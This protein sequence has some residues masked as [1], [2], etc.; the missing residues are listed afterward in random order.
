MRPSALTLAP[1]VSEEELKALKESI[2]SVPLR[3]KH[4][5]IGTAAGGTL[6]ELMTGYDEPRPPFVVVDTFE[7]FPNQRAA[8]E[9][10]LRD[11]GID[12]ADIDIREG[13]SWDLC[14]KALRDREK[15]DFIFIDGHHGANYVMKD[16]RWTRMLSPGGLV[17]LHDYKPDFPGVIWA[18]ERFLK[19]NPNY[20]KITHT[21]TLVILRK[22]REGR[23]E[24]SWKE[25][26]AGEVFAKRLTMKKS[27][28]KRLRRTK[29]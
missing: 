28:N 5:E 4:L 26:I 7:Y 3:G 29:S 27:L 24:V 12:P 10:N 21:G 20:E 19:Q 11:A 15:F 2:F 18:T 25:V 16:L 8:V 6:R 22:M 9:K 14:R 13:R 1:E 17:C 23:Q